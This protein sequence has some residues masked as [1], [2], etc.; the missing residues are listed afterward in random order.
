MAIQP[1]DATGLCP[2]EVD[3]GYFSRIL[4]DW[5]ARLRKLINPRNRILQ[6]QAQA[7]AKQRSEAIRFAR[8]NLITAQQAYE[9]QANRHRQP[10]DWTVN[11]NIY[12]RKGNWTTNR[13]YNE[14]NN[15]YLRPYKMLSNLYP[16]IYEIDLPSNIK[17][18]RFLNASRLIKAKDNLVPE[19][20][21]KPENLV[22]INKKLE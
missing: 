8:N 20:L 3:L 4:F 16:N 17:A 13:P 1:H 12:V 9:K 10:V 19:Q 6:Q 22:N 15:P 2:A 14:L 5:E 7:F 11:N 21:L 18:R